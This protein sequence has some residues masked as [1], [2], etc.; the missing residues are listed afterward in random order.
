M[1][2]ANTLIVSY[3]DD[4]GT[5]DPHNYDSPMWIQS[6]VYEGL[7]RYV[8]G[9]VVPAMAESWEISDDGTEYTF[10]LRE[11]AVFSDGTPVN[12]EIVKKIWMLFWY[13]RL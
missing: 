13:D 1:T 6:L 8:D 12:A 9:E 4:I 7:T 2:E 5:L 10:Y 3:P 11:G